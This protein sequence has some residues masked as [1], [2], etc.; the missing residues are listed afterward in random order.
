MEAFS[1]GVLAIIITLMVLEMEPPHS[2]TWAGLA[3]VRHQFVIYLLSFGFLA[4]YWNNHHHLLQ[5]AHN[6]NGRILWA[7]LHLLF[8]LSLVPYT[9][10]WVSE[11][12]FAGVPVAIYGVVFLAAGLAY[13]LL[14]RALI[15]HHGEASPLARAVG[16]DWKARLSLVFYAVGVLVA[17]WQPLAAFGIYVL[18]GLSWFIPDRRIERSLEKEPP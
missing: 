5:A 16:K 12:H 11:T 9:T 13:F 15:A 7:N 18:V 4:I 17:T 14:S 6:V 2:A 3:Q 8:W 1:D 10:D